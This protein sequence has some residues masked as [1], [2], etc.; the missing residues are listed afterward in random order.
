MNTPINFKLAKLLEQR[1]IFIKS[2][3]AY[4]FRFKEHTYS[5]YNPT[6]I[7]KDILSCDIKAPIISDV[8]MWI[9]DKYGI[10]IGV[11]PS[12]DGVEWYSEMFTASEKVWFD[13]DKRH[14]INTA[15]RKYKSIHN[16]PT[17][18]YE[19]GIEYTLNKLI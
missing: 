18:A 11:K 1:Q 10:W 14:D 17:E 7:Y 16:S 3:V 5:D 2:S 6:L 8:V 9:Y 4:P 13:I 15:F 12:C 19:A